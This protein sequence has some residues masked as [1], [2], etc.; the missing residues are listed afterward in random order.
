MQSES[1]LEEDVTPSMF[2]NLRD[3]DAYLPGLR[4][5]KRVVGLPYSPA[6]IVFG[7]GI[8]AHG[9]HPGPARPNHSKTP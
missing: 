9:N 5:A 2:R 7:G 3:N 6:I 1:F 4:Q 8:G